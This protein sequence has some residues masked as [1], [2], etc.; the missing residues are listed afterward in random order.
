MHHG[1]EPSAC[2]TPSSDTV[3]NF[4]DTSRS[5]SLP[6]LPPDIFRTS[7]TNIL[8]ILFRYHPSGVLESELATFYHHMFNEW[9]S[10]KYHV[11]YFLQTHSAITV[12]TTKQHGL[13]YTLNPSEISNILQTFHNH[14]HPDILN[15]HIS[16]HILRLFTLFPHG[17]AC[18]CF[19]ESFQNVFQ[20][21]LADAM[22]S[23]L[24]F[25]TTN[26]NIKCVNVCGYNVLIPAC[27]FPPLDEAKIL[28]KPCGFR[29]LFRSLLRN[30]AFTGTAFEQA[31]EKAYGWKLHHEAPY[32]SSILRQYKVVKPHRK[33]I[34][35]S[36]FRQDQYSVFM[37]G[38]P[39]PTSIEQ[40]QSELTAMGFVVVRCTEIK[41]RKFGYSWVTLSKVEEADALI[42]R[43]PVRMLGVS[44]DVRPYI[45]REQQ[46]NQPPDDDA[47]L[48]MMKKLVANNKH[49]HGVLSVGDIQLMLF[50][51]LS[52][53]VSGTQLIRI[54]KQNPDNFSGVVCF[55]CF[56]E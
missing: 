20:F 41:Y 35:K 15:Q 39:R 32:I 18:G 50:K 48:K 16:E 44:I 1:K 5:P 6:P 47:I 27:T 2:A 46:H 17:I 49:K 37:G 25:L 52:Y 26:P 34:Q 36:P 11:Q 21:K 12:T 56:S 31:F 24:Y 55:P 13:L 38:F 29:T 43:S 28:T 54:L 8:L 30:N 53:R 10:I 42:Q 22:P 40:I 19:E 9:I 4:P 45:N 33:K 23:L 7:E 3:P 14:F 51:V